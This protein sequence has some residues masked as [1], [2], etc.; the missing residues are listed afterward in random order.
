MPQKMKVLP[1]RYLFGHYNGTLHYHHTPSIYKNYYLFPMQQ[2]WLH[3]NLHYK[4]Y[5]KGYHPLALPFLHVHYRI[6]RVQ[7][8]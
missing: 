1:P 5:S 2:Q 8:K 7:L 3:T 4:T 6:T